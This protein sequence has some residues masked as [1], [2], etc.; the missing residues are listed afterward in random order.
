MLHKKLS[1]EKIKA[2]K[3]Y[4]Y[5]VKARGSKTRAR[6]LMINTQH[7][8]HRMLPPPL[9]CSY[10]ILLLHLLLLYTSLLSSSSSSSPQPIK[11]PSLQLLELTELHEAIR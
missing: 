2:T 11:K 1:I 3:Q 10:L 6:V 4:K 5:L 7:A 9:S 8:C